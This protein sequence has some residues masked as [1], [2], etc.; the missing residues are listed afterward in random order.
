MSPC[1]EIL[2]VQT[3]LAFKKDCPTRQVAYCHGKQVHVPG[4]TCEILH[5]LRVYNLRIIQSCIS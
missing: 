5:I 1:F 3:S 2:A 4:R